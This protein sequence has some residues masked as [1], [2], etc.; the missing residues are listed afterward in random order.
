MA[1]R[2][3]KYIYGPVS[4][5]RLGRSLGVDLISPSSS[6]FCNF[7]CIYCQLGKTKTFSGERKVFVPTEEILKEIKLL[8]SVKIDYITFSGQ[9]EPTLALNLGEAIEKIRKLRKDKIAVLTNSSIINRMDVQRDLKKA[10]FVMAK[11]EAH[12][13]FLF[14]KING[15]MK[16]IKFNNIVKGLKQFSSHFKG[17][18]ALQVMFTEENKK[19]AKEIA[20]LTKSI[21]PDEIQI[22]TPLRPCGVKPL[23]T[24]E[25]NEIKRF[26]KSTSLVSV[27]GAKTKKVKPT[28]KNTMLKRRG[29]I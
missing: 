7:D 20:E 13:E 18:L 27:Y 2:T 12:K 8:A 10:D 4:S 24:E 11:L 22:N 1:Q 9:G 14:K 26:F 25:L 29:I 15:P 28:T 19:Y 3:F 17:R 16:G 21:N 5:W 6:K 23:P